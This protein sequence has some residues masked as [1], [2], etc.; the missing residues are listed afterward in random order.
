MSQLATGAVAISLGNKADLQI[1]NDQLVVTQYDDRGKI[2]QAIPLG[3]AT[4]DRFDSLVEYTQR[5][6]IHAID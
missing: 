3:K 4:Q 2:K 5:L 1:V 6:S